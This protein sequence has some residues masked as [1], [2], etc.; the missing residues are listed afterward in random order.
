MAELGCRHSGYP[1]R[2]TGREVEGPGREVDGNTK[3][4]L[5][6]RPVYFPARFNHT[7]SCCIVASQNGEWKAPVVADALVKKKAVSI[8][9]A[10]LGSQHF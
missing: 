1:A 2:L 9:K 7:C 8:E 4:A 6:A 5:P 3:V 10:I